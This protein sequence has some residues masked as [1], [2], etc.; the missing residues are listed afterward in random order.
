VADPLVIDSDLELFL[1]GWYRTALAGTEAALLAARIGASS[2]LLTGVEVDNK[3]P[4][5]GHVPGE[6]ARHP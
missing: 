3:E 1:T 4:S 6:A 2:G 5:D